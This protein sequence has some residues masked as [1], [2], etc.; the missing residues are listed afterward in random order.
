MTSG[1][2]QAL[3]AIASP[4]RQEII[5]LVWSEELPAG[6]IAAR[7]EISWPAVSQNLRVLREAGLV[8][9]RREGTHRFYRAD[10]A[11]LGPLEPV[12]RR[13]WRSNLARL[14]ELA[15]AEA[16]SSRR[17]RSRTTARRRTR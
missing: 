12:L 6:E 11:A 10:R 9:E 7:F 13:M 15:E 16:G 4:T 14:K 8:L 2:Q 5:R 17:S 1:M 3:D